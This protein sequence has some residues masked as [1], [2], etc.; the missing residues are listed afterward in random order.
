MPYSRKLTSLHVISIMEQVAR[1]GRIEISIACPEEPIV[2]SNGLNR[3]L[4]LSVEAPI[5]LDMV[6]R[7]IH[8]S[9]RASFIEDMTVIRRGHEPPPRTY[10]LG[11]AIAQARYISLKYQALLGGDGCVQKIVALAQDVSAEETLLRSK[12]HNARRV[13]ALMAY[14]GVECIW[15][16]DAGGRLFEHFTAGNLEGVV[17][18]FDPLTADAIHPGDREIALSAIAR[19]MSA[20]EGFSVS[21]RIFGADG[22]PRKYHKRG[23]VIREEGRPLEWWGVIIEDRALS[24]LL[25]AELDRA[26]KLATGATLRALCGVVGYTHDELAR[27]TGISRTTIHRMF[28]SDEP[29]SGQ[30]KYKTVEAVIQ[31]FTQHGIRFFV[32]PE[33]VLAFSHR[34]DRK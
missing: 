1:L 32:D 3:L 33:G 23:M 28:S 2:F 25:P 34:K 31:I 14:F 8:A 30:F 5:T 16:A 20:G 24:A 22:V 10:R 11:G 9:D 13:D 19:A 6:S 15:S 29:L 26:V 17:P 21:M 18:N 27:H 7:A 12:T 4:G